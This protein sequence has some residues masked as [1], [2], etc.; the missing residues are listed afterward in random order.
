MFFKGLQWL[1]LDFSIKQSWD[2]RRVLGDLG[3]LPTQE[4]L[5]SQQLQTQ[6]LNLIAFIL[7][8]KAMDIPAHSALPKLFFLPGNALS[9]LFIHHVPRWSL[10]QSSHLSCKGLP[11][12]LGVFLVPGKGS[13]TLPQTISFNSQSP[14]GRCEGSSHMSGAEADT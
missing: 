10:S 14:A 6:I 3:T 7:L 5:D 12:F 4:S 8:P 9:W 1:P 2:V 11:C 13:Q